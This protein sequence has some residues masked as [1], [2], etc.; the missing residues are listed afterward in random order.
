MINHEVGHRDRLP[1]PRAVR[2]ERQLAPVMM[3]QTFFNID[4]DASRLTPEYVK[5]DGKTCRFN[6]WPYPIA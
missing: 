3:Q 1:A 2:Q 5:A 4:D 6:P